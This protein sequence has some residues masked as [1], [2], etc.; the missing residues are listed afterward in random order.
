MENIK[1]KGDA[2]SLNLSLN[3]NIQKIQNLDKFQLKS[4]KNLCRNMTGEKLLMKDDDEIVIGT[5]GG[6]INKKRSGIVCFCNISMYSPGNHFENE[7]NTRVPYLYNYI[8]DA[9][10]RKH[11]ISY[12][13]MDY[14]KNL[15][16]K[17]KYINLDILDD[18]IIAKKFFEK[19]GF[20]FVKDFNAGG[21]KFLSYTSGPQTLQTTE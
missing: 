16:C 21:K 6:T 9:F 14:I 4:L 1:V 18:N 3:L 2:V 8:C 19:N 17:E 13:M 20:V 15:Y 5:I 12:Q 11:K 10:Y 7:K